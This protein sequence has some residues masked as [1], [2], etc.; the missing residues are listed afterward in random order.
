MAV[1]PGDEGIVQRYVEYLGSRRF[2]P[3][4]ARVAGRPWGHVVMALVT[5]ATTVGIP[6]AVY[7]GVKMT[8]HRKRRRK[9]MSAAAR[10]A[11]PIRTYPLMVNRKL[12]STPGAVAPGM[13]IGSFRPHPAQDGEYWLD[14]AIK[15]SLLDADSLESREEKEA[16]KWLADEGY[17][18]SRRLRL[19]TSLTDGHEVYAFHLM[20][21]GDH[22]RGG[23]ID[24]EPIPCVAVPGLVG[25]IQHTPW[26][27]DGGEAPPA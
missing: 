27:I 6:I 8:T 2:D 24:G 25:A 13:V 18:E 17:V 10:V 14:L 20:I 21:V 9:A 11:K 16:A 15:L 7:H 26:W 4:L 23:V 22:L 3:V 12:T 5:A 1:Q 19:P